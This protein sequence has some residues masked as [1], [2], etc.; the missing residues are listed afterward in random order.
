[1][2]TNGWLR[3]L[4]PGAAEEHAGAFEDIVTTGSVKAE[5]KEAKKGQM[6]EKVL[7]GRPFAREALAVSPLLVTLLTVQEVTNHYES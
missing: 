5:R 2:Q 1:M 7:K 3:T 4:R 6:G